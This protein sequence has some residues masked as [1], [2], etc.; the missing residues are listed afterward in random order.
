MTFTNE[1]IL[2][3][4]GSRRMKRHR[5]KTAM[6]WMRPGGNRKMADHA[7]PG[8]KYSQWDLQVLHIIW[9][10]IEN[11]HGQLSTVEKIAANVPRCTGGLKSLLILHQLVV[12]NFRF[13]PAQMDD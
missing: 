3:S 13:A 9:E 6:Q 2:Q 7:N 8:P 12:P 4:G 5:D 10:E 11:S 1:D